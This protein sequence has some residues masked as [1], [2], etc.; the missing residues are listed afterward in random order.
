MIRAIAVAALFCMLPMA[1]TAADMT[2]AAL[3]L[4][5]PLT[6]PECKFESRYGSSVLHDLASTETC[7]HDVRVI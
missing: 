1:A 6:L 7:S 2:I 5:A 4:G 3:T